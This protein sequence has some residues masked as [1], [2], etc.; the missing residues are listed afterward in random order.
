[1]A[2]PTDI[3]P[4]Q[5]LVDGLNQPET[6][7]YSDEQLG[8]IFRSYVQESFDCSWDGFSQR[9]RSAIFRMLNDM[10]IYAKNYTEQP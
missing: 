8:A 6:R 3:R 1:M 5:Q 4:I 10:A 2:Q 7:T 9:D